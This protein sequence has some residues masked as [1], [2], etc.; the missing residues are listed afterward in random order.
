MS[1]F[2]EVKTADLVGAALDWA[3]GRALGAEVKPHAFCEAPGSY[4][5]PNCTVFPNG[6]AA[7]HWQPSTDWSQGGPL[8]EKFGVLLSPKESMVH[9][10]GGP[11][12]G[13]QESGSWG[14][15]IFRKGEHRRKAHNHESEPLVAAMRCVVGW[16]LGETVSVPKE[17]LS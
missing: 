8:I 5:H 11:N 4:L 13:W 17:L 10:H 16:S 12:A 14:A 7:S 9:V 1:E 2:V 15:T 3:V 6:R